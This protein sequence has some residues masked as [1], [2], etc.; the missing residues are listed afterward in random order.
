MIE[1]CGSEYLKAF[2]ELAGKNATYTSTNSVVGFVEVLGSWVERCLLKQVQQA[3]FIMVDECTDI[4]TVEE[5]SIFFRWVKD[6]VLVENFLGIL[7]L[8]KADAVTIHSTLIKFLN[9]KEIQLG[10]FVGM[11]FDGAITFLGSTKVYRAY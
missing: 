1:S 11:G 7:P 3:Q 5:L 2:K 9:E 4:T 10:K 8:K 6:G